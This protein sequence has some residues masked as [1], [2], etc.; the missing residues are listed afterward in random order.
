MLSLDK[1][2]G[3]EV[4]Q[5]VEGK[6]EVVHCPQA[7]SL[8]QASRNSTRDSQNCMG[9]ALDLKDIFSHVTGSV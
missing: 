4:F 3:L 1:H 2:A 6:Q 7:S 9:C 5:V 8:S